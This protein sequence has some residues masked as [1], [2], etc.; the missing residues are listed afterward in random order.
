MTSSELLTKLD[1][2]KN[3]GLIPVIVQDVNT[4]TV[5]MLAYTN[6]EALDLTMKT[7][8][9]TY[10]SRSRNEIWVKGETSGH[11]QQIIEISADC[12]YDTLL[13]MVDQKNNACHTGSYSC[14]FNKLQ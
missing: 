2:N 3:N 8:K 11:T 6:R 5:L 7:G 12:D 1:F 9:A 13:Y 4:K 10:W 14:F